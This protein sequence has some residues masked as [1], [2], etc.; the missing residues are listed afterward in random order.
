MKFVNDDVIEFLLNKGKTHSYSTDIG[1]KSDDALKFIEL[2][3]KNDAYIL[4]G[5]VMQKVDNKI[6]FTY[7]SWYS[8]PE[9]YSKE[10]SYKRAID[11]ITNY[12]LKENKYF[13]FVWVDNN[14]TFSLLKK[15]LTEK[16]K[17]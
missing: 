11:Y 5:D 1:L 13:S 3:K 10:E 16:N 15:I 17:L 9:Q 8:D 7:D 2:L 6:D 12:P 4:G 14:D